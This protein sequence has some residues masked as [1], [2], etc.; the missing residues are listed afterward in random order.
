MTGFISVTA[1]NLEKPSSLTSSGNWLYVGGSGPGNYTTIQDA[2]DHASDSDTVFVFDDSSPYKGVIFV[3]KSLTIHG[4]N[5]NTTIID[6]GGFNISA[7]HVTITGFTVQNSKT[8][9]YIKGSGPTASYTTVDNNIFSNVSRGVNIYDDPWWTLNFTEIGYNI[10]SNNV[11]TYTTDYG[12]TI[13]KGQ[14]NIVIGN[15]ISQNNEYTT[16]AYTIGIYISSAF[17][18]I[19]YNNIH[20]NIRGIHLVESNKTEIYRN[21]I[22]GNK[23]FGM[24][25]INPSFVRVI[26]NNFINNRRSVRIL[27]YIVEP[28]STYTHLPI[29]PAFFD[30]NYWDKSRIFPYPISSFFMYN[31]LYF[32]WFLGGIFGFE[33][34]EFILDNFVNFVRFDWHPAQEPY[35]ILMIRG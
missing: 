28:M 15:D 11:I 8:G 35:D 17:N 2:V 24:F 3:S 16:E 19:S 14:N 10:I 27:R 33:I 29:Q 30:E 1:Q 34:E 18:N 20:D 5:K 25:L 4:E 26:Q 6:S 31:P 13:A 7:N 22:K 9:V 21:T 12:I 32:V 23:D